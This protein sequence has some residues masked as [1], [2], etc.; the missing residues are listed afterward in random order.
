MSYSFRERGT[1]LAEVLFGAVNPSGK[2]AETL[3]EDIRQRFRK[4]SVFPGK[5]SG[6]MEEKKHMNA[7]FDT[8]LMGEGIFAGYRYLRKCNYDKGKMKYKKM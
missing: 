6:Q 1:A 8:R 5:T 4:E 3:P 7:P 2:S